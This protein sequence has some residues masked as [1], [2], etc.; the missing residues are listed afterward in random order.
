MEDIKEV[1]N[2]QYLLNGDNIGSYR[3]FIEDEMKN[4]KANIVKLSSASFIVSMLY[5][6]INVINSNTIN[7]NYVISIILFFSMFIIK[8][9]MKYFDRKEDL[10]IFNNIYYCIL[11]KCKDINLVKNYNKHLNN[12]N[13]LLDS[14]I[15]LP[16]LKKDFFKSIIIDKFNK[17]LRIVDQEEY[18]FSTRVFQSSYLLTRDLEEQEKVLNNNKSIC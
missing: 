5:V 4:S 14:S 9:S 15:D 8:D 13:N 6:F 11:N 18:A 2:V 3:D 17:Y 12:V 7:I 16:I 10:K 1:E